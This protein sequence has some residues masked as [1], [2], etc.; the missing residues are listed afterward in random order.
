MGGFR[1]INTDESFVMSLRVCFVTVSARTGDF[2]N[3]CSVGC[4]CG[5]RRVRG[6]GK[7]R[8]K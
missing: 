5:G 7:G 8:G 4:V 2:C 1:F 6:G 3:Y